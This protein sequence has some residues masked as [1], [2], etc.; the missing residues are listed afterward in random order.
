M[1]H[2]E[3]T[4][5]GYAIFLLTNHI[6]EVTTKSVYHNQP[7]S[8]DESA[9]CHSTKADDSY[10]R[11]KERIREFLFSVSQHTARESEM[12]F[13]H[14]LENI[15]DS[16]Y[17]EEQLLHLLDY[18]RIRK[19]WLL[20]FLPAYTT[21]ASEI[22]AIISE[23]E[24]FESDTIRH[25]FRIATQTRQP[26]LQEQYQSMNPLNEKLQVSQQEQPATYM[27]LQQRIRQLEERE[28]F[29]RHVLDTTPDLI[30]ILD[31]V[32]IKILYANREL[33]NVLGY[34]PQ[35]LTGWGNNYMQH[36]VVPQ[37]LPMVYAHLQ[38]LVDAE[39]NK[40]YVIEYRV[41]DASGKI[42]WLRTRET[43]FKRNN[44]GKVREILSITA[45]ITDI[46]LAEA[47]RSYNEAL[48]KE[49][50]AVSKLGNWEMDLSENKMYGSEEFYRILQCTINHPLEF[51]SIIA[52]IHPEDARMLVG[53]IRNAREQGEAYTAEYRMVQPGPSIVYHFTK[54]WAIRNENDKIIKL[55]G[56]VQDITDRKLAEQELKQAYLQLKESNEELSRTEKLLNKLNNELE[57]RVQQRTAAL[58][59][60]NER[61]QLIAEATNDA[62]WDR[63]FTQKYVRWNKSFENVFGY[64]NDQERQF[65][66]F[67]AWFQRVHP[68][69]RQMAVHTVETVIAQGNNF[70]KM[71][72]RFM[73]SDGTYLFVLERGR[74]LFDD[75]GAP[76]MTLGSIMDI[77]G[78]KYAEQ[79]LIDK[80][81]E[82]QRIN[83]DLD[84][85]IY[86]ASHDLKNPVLNLEGLLSILNQSLNHK[87]EPGDKKW[88]DLMHVALGRL[89]KTINDLTEINKI[90]KGTDEI[91]EVLEFTHLVEDIR[92]DN[93]RL[94]TEAN[95]R[96][97]TDFKVTHIHYP[98]KNL[99]SILH[100]LLT[101]AVKYRSPDRLPEIIITTFQQ[102]NYIVLHVTDNG[103][104]FA[105]DLKE[106]V[107]AMFK[108]LHTHVEGTGIGLY[109]IKRMIENY[110]GS[111]DVDS[112]PG[113]GSTFKVY[114]KDSFVP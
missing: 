33:V 40:I 93:A 67:N 63:L 57:Q 56:I 105:P 13:M 46:K 30:R 45:D 101:N 50:Q 54:G 26:V 28:Y 31:I 4:F 43:V 3:K 44:T 72:Y 81:V 96:I 99:R 98:A 9:P 78:L 114:F 64:L 65:P 80:N 29:I 110:G 86:T 66:D 2:I 59:E 68:E 37:D 23:M 22:I 48:L 7:Q 17:R 61:F 1:A 92:Q 11:E 107:F 27:E 18:R 113:Q 111:I 95:A 84:N 35:Q 36:I 102:N 87:I 24:Q 58:E 82:L 32:E 60:S 73:R 109:M 100:N 21:D 94:I 52:N 10:I 14:T 15:P 97:I 51:Q 71:E 25:S 19:Q 5:A 62:V 8:S 76:Y 85:F 34:T 89:K 12:A 41:T 75:T 20:Q 42:R 53:K 112:T 77:S 103:L 6:D 74:I 79:E 106:K 83:A 47:K 16:S 38:E 104:G 70:W 91:R 69:D 88:M 39:D 108:R 55:R 49:S 90:Q